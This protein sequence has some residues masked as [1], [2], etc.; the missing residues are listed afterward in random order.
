MESAGRT[1]VSD[2]IHVNAG[3]RICGV[4][5]SMPPGNEPIGPVNGV[6]PGFTAKYNS[7]RGR[8]NDL[9]FMRICM[10]DGLGVISSIYSSAHP[11]SDYRKISSTMSANAILGRLRSVC[12]P[13]IGRAYTD[14]EIASLS[15]TIDGVMKGM[16]SENY[17][18]RIEVSLTASRFDRINGVLRASVTFVPPLSLEAINVEITLEA[19]TAGI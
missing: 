18:Q 19:P 11:T 1:G 17:A 9:A 6:V 14:Q 5:N 8:L 12:G 15:Q 4:L 3:P 16:V 13:Y 7:D 10:V 2:S